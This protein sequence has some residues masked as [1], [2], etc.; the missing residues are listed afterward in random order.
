MDSHRNVN[1]FIIGICNYHECLLRNYLVYFPL[2]PRYSQWYVFISLCTTLGKSYTSELQLIK[3]L[4]CTDR[5]MDFFKFHCI[6]TGQIAIKAWLYPMS[7]VWNVFEAF[8]ILIRL[9]YNGNIHRE[10]ESFRFRIMDKHRFFIKFI[11]FNSIL[12]FLNSWICFFNFRSN[13]IPL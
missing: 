1:H 10:I 6:L 7:L 11:I 2:S 9:W 4:V 3:V 5:K 8:L 13:Y 12:R